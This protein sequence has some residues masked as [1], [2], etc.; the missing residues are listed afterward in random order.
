MV[1]GNCGRR[2]WRRTVVVSIDL[3]RYHPSAS[4]SEHVSF[5]ARTS[6]GYTVYAL[7]H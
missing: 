4:L 3:R 1:R 5:V 6:S 7:G 2:I